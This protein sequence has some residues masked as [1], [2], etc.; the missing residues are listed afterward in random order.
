M[1]TQTIL[2]KLLKEAEEGGDARE[3]VVE[4][5]SYAVQ[6][7]EDRF[8]QQFDQV[9]ADISSRSGKPSFGD[10]A[11]VDGVSRVPPPSWLTPKSTM[12]HKILKT[13]FWKEGGNITYVQF[14]YEMDRK[15]RPTTYE[16][17]LGAR[18]TVVREKPTLEV[19]RHHD[20]PSG[21][22]AFWTFFVSLFKFS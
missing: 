22:R 17:L 15:Q 1:S 4:A 6:N 14:R 5:A 19:A 16:I 2:E 10:G 11:G 3:H 12:Q 7:V 8:N 9:V 21:L 20:G 13:T 18:R